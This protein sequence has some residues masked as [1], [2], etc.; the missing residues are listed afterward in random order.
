[1][2]ITNSIDNTIETIKDSG[3]TAHEINAAYLN[4]LS[5]GDYIPKANPHCASD[6]DLNTITNSGFYRLNKFTN[7]PSDG[8]GSYGQL[9]VSHGGD[10]ITQIL[11][12]YSESSM[13]V[14]SGNP[15]DAGG[16]GAWQNWAKLASQTWVENKGYKTTDTNTTYSVATTSSPGLMSTVDKSKVDSLGTQ[17]TY[18]YS[19]GTLT[20]TTK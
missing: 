19:S 3:G 15:S 20:I 14:R 8:V 4:G 9:I 16:T 10:T 17:A 2:A 13:Y 18:S 7:G 1:M 5:S 12:P 6:T 11:C